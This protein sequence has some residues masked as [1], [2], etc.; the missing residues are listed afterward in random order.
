MAVSVFIIISN[1][2][3][4]MFLSLKHIYIIKFNIYCLFLIL[5]NLFMKI[6]QKH[7]P[8]HHFLLFVIRKTW[9]FLC[10]LQVMQTI[11]P[12]KVKMPLLI[13][14]RREFCLDAGIFGLNL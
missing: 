12:R 4:S 5:I 8:A 14:Q 11:N 3:I 2:F 1:S 7:F 6:F 13:V 9:L 10:L